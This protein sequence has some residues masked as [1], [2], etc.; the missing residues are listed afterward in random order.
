[1]YF[2]E[3]AGQANL[4]VERMINDLGAEEFASAW[5][6]VTFFIGANDLCDYCND[7]V[8]ICNL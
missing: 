2:S 8:R 1:V 4:L 6:L 5:K 7:P 3:M